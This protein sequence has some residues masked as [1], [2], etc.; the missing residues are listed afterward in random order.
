MDKGVDAAIG[1]IETH[2]RAETEKL[3]TGLPLIPRKLRK[4][5]KINLN[6]M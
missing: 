4:A 2:G 3:L 1:Y 5:L 6:N